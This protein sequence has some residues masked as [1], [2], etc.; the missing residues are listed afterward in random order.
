MSEMVINNTLNIGDGHPVWTVA[1][2][3]LCHNGDLGLAESM[4]RACAEQGA[5]AVKLQKRDVDNLAIAS[6]LDA[7]DERFP[8]FGSTYRQVRRHIEFDLEQYRHLQA[9][10]NAIGIPLFTSVFDVKSAQEMASL[11]MPLMKVASHCLSHRP[12]IDCVCEM[13]IPTLLSTG[14]ATWE[15][16]DATVA[17]LSR[18]RTPFGLYHCVSDYPHTYAT[19]N[20]KLIGVMRERYGVPVGYSSH[21]LDNES[22]FLAVAM[23]AFSIEKH[24]TLDRGMEGFDHRIAQDMDGLQHLVAGIRRAEQALGKGDKFVSEKE[25]VTRQKYHFSVVSSQRIAA[26]ATISAAMITV[27]NPAGGIAA[28]D[29]HSV[30][31]K[32]A[33]AAIATD[34]LITWDMLEH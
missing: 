25:M 27:K 15:E 10:A 12:L 1:E 19:A 26:G 13:G 3:G 11:E 8:S 7:K 29:F 6:V 31:G 33:K 5:D 9:C 20:L 28:K 21:E 17:L 4:I 14:M 32:K 2:I 24:V 18:S 22:A 16:I 23:G 30:V 34:E